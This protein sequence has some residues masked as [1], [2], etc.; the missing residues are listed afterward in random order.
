ME[1]IAYLIN[2]HC[3]LVAVNTHYETEKDGHRVKIDNAKKLYKLGDHILIGVIGDEKK[4]ANIYKFIFKRRELNPALSYQDIIDDLS[5]IFASDNEKLVE[6]MTKVSKIVPAYTNEADDKIDAERMAREHPE[7]A[8]TLDE[9][10]AMLEAGDPVV[11]QVFVFGWDAPTQQCRMV[12]KIYFGN[13]IAGSKDDLVWGKDQVSV[14][15]TS[16]SMAIALE[17]LKREGLAREYFHGE[18]FPGWDDDD[19]QIAHAL[20]VGRRALTDGIIGMNPY[21]DAP[22]IVFYELSVGTGFCFLEPAGELVGI[23]S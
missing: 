21:D 9:I 18:I 1:S 14:R 4:A 11:T 13:T 16:S 3:L 12:H 19:K 20:T 22:N 15:F 2:R 23:G 6:T 17:N 5:D 8:D 10:L 7:F